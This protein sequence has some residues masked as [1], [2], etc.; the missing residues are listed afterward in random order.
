MALE[1]TTMTQKTEKN[2]RG[3]GRKSNPCKKIIYSV[4]LP[5]DVVAH[6]KAQPNGPKFVLEAIL[7]YSK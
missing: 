3:A 6:I 2:P 1:D 4:K 7:A 5:P